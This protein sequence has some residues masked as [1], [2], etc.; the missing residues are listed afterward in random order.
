ML[1]RKDI[2]KIGE[3]LL[4]EL[5]VNS[6]REPWRYGVRVSSGT[7][8]KPLI[9]VMEYGEAQYSKYDG[10]SAVMVCFGPLNIRLAH[11]LHV[12]KSTSA[13]P[14]RIMFVDGD[15][16]ST[17]LA[18]CIADF[19]PDTIAG[20][21]VFVARVAEYFDSKSA[22]G[23]KELK[24]AGERVTPAL[25]E[26][27]ARQFPNARIQ[28]NYIA[29]EIGSIATSGCPHLSLNQYH[30]NRGVTVEILNADETGEGDIVV[31]KQLNSKT[32]V[33]KYAL[34][35]TGRFIPGPCACGAEVTFE[36]LGR[37]GYDYI[38]LVGATI[39]REEFDRVAALLVNYV[40]DYRAEVGEKLVGGKLKGD[41]VL[42]IFSRKGPGTPALA[43]EIALEFSRAVFL[44]PTQTLADLVAKGLFLPLVVEFSPVPFPQKNKEIKLTRS[45]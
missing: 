18:H 32:R 14:Q 15:D 37:K 22:S 17:E 41:I 19:T 30:P 9:S 20:F 45:E 5:I 11:A 1:N 21:P 36:H 6:P 8:G 28:V 39:R 40:D 23:V 13:E 27:F 35:D 29:N 10:S 7:T 16:L 3:Q 12:A 2:A 4:E 25:A 26:L 43:E 42:R 34:G 38:K 33:E 24:F 44:T 31:S